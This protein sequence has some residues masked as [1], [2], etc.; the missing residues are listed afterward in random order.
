MKT[1]I[2]CK[3]WLKLLFSPAFLVHFWIF[4]G[5]VTAKIFIQ[6]LRR[7]ASKHIRENP[8]FRKGCESAYGCTELFVG[9]KIDIYLPHMMHHMTKRSV[10]KQRKCRY[11]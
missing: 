1:F 11:M 7:R 4:V 5:N 10:G 6:T 2:F 8:H 3:K 9:I